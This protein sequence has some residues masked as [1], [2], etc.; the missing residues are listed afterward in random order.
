MKK[1]G[2]TRLSKLS[3]ATALAMFALT[4][5]AI[6]AHMSGHVGGGVHGGAPG[7]GAQFHGNGGGAAHGIVPVPHHNAGGFKPGGGVPQVRHFNGG[8]G[9]GGNVAWHHER[10]E[11]HANNQWQ[12]HEH[13]G[14]HRHHRLNF[15]V[16]GAPYYDSFDDYA[17]SYN[18]GDC[19]YYLRRYLQT[20]NPLWKHRFQDCVS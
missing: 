5:V 3:A 2:M 10:H 19:G 12:H 1:F 20:G 11:H 6:A 13:H 8:G 7:G 18:G 9:G 4:P 17:Y 15:F 14:H 16:Y